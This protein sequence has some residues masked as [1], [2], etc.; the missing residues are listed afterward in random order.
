MPDDPGKCAVFTAGACIWSPGNP[1]AGWA[2]CYGADGLRNPLFY[3]GPVRAKGPDMLHAQLNSRAELHA[4]VAALK[5][6]QWSAEGFHTLV[7]V[8]D[9]FYVVNGATA[10][11]KTWLQTGWKSVH[12][13]GQ[14]VLDQDLWETLLEETKYLEGEGMAVEFWRIP[15]QWN[16]AGD[17]AVT[18]ALSRTDTT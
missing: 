4:V 12:R 2:F 3:Q 9:S 16:I 5:F 10:Q 11:I 7:I 13:P 14:T 17:S 8:T 1:E 6:K 15:P 18:A